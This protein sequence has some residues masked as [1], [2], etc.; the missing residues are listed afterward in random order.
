MSEPHPALPL[1]DT[2]D[3]AVPARACVSV[4]P[5]AS[6]ARS[7]VRR[8]NAALRGA[9]VTVALID[10]GVDR[11]HAA[12]DGARLACGPRFGAGG[13]ITAPACDTDP[14]GH[15]TR[16][17]SAIVG[18]RGGVAPDATLLALGAVAPGG[19]TTAD[20]LLAALRF[21][22]DH[23][24][25]DVLALPLSPGPATSAGDVDRVSRA[26]RALAA[27]GVLV[28]VASG[29]AG[30][31]EL[32]ESANPWA[33]VDGVL[34]VGGEFRPGAF[35]ERSGRSARHGVPHVC[36]PCARV[37]V[38]VAE[39]PGAWETWDGGTSYACA[40]VAAAAACVLGDA[41]ELR[42]DPAALAAAVIQLAVPLRGGPSGAP[43]VSIRLPLA[44]DGRRSAATTPR[45]STARHCQENAA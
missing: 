13:G 17:A 28:V 21:V 25:I 35:Y 40:V 11:E 4:E 8:G 10:T 38:P 3:R 23:G 14:H 27:R 34:S 39:H 1:H 18:C 6:W 15:G 33:C 42:R 9:G 32:D 41:H 5:D 43:P 29:N 19:A 24:A 22:A 37:L 20:A 2:H 36:A 30:R 31:A 16:L 12:F 44:S 45:R 7:T 26:L